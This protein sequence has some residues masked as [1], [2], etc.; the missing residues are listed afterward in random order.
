MFSCC[1]SVCATPAQSSSIHR[2]RFFGC[3]SSSRTWALASANA[4][5]SNSGPIC[6]SHVGQTQAFQEGDLGQKHLNDH[7]SQ[8]GF[9]SCS[10]CAMCQIK[11]VLFAL[12][13]PRQGF[14]HVEGQIS[15]STHGRFCNWHEATTEFAHRDVSEICQESV[16]MLSPLSL[17]CFL[18]RWSKIR[19]GPGLP[20]AF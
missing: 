14:H 10:G 20:A 16:R 18:N 8:A 17:S 4:R 15:P 5:D 2:A 9:R 3:W 6:R 12:F 7:Y 19:K 13:A 1:Q 11:T